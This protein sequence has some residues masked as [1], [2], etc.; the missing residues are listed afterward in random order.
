MLLWPVGGFRRRDALL[1]L[2]LCG[3]AFYL[4]K[5]KFFAIFSFLPTQLIVFGSFAVMR[6]NML[7]LFKDLGGLLNLLPGAAPNRL[8]P[9]LVSLG[10]LALL[11]LGNLWTWRGQKIAGRAELTAVL[12]F[13]FISSGAICAAF[14]LLDTVGQDY[15]ARFLLNIFY[16]LVIVL[17]VLID[18]NWRIMP[19]K[20]LG[21]AVACLFVVASLSSTFAIWTTRHFTLQDNDIPQEIAFLQQNGLSYGYGPYHGSQSSA[22]TA[23][24][25]G[26]LTI[27]PV[28]FSPVTGEMRTYGRPAT[29]ASWFTA[30]DHPADQSR[31]FVMVV[32]DGEECPDIA[33][34]V[35]GLTAQYGTPD[36]TL[37]YGGAKVLVWSHPLIGYR[38]EVDGDFWGDDGGWA[39]MGRSIT[40]TSGRPLVFSIQGTSLGA[41][42]QID[43]VMNGQNKHFDLTTGQTTTLEVPAHSVLQVTASPGFIADHMVHNG[44][45]R[46]L[47]VLVKLV[48]ATP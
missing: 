4:I 5:S 34:C 47:T 44:D 18:A 36:K 7:Y 41:V 32:S 9:G 39:W 15:S 17:G 42:E 35:R 14:V 33:L 45:M 29:A 25:N 31:F 1:L 16:L 48:S 13:A 10:V 19:A 20:I 22:V 11:L 27:R 30:G 46:H 26:A 21:G 23:I 37:P 43:T 8:G 28:T 6:H 40:V 12:V 38:Y 2:L 24:T 3:I